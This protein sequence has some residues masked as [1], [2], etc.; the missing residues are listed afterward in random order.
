M[1]INNRVNPRLIFSILTVFCLIIVSVSCK[2]NKQTK[3]KAERHIENYSRSEPDTAVYNKSQQLITKLSTAFGS[4][5]PKEG[6]TPDYY[7]GLYLNEQGRMV[8]QIIGD[9]LA[10][11]QKIAEIVGSNDF[12]V[13]HIVNTYSNRE[14]SAIMDKLNEAWKKAD[15]SVTRNIQG[16]GVGIHHIFVD[17][18]VNTEEK[19][20][21]FRE[22]VMDSPAFIFSRYENPMPISPEGSSDTCGVHLR[23]EYPVYHTSTDK[24]KFILYN[25]S[26]KDLMCGEHYRIGF[27]DTDGHWKELPING[28]AIDIGYII[29]HNGQKEFTADLYQDV[30]PNNPGNYRFFYNARINDD[31][32]LVAD[33]KLTDDEEFARSVQKNPIVPASLLD[34]DTDPHSSIQP[35]ADDRFYAERMPEFPGGTKAMND[36]I[37][38][39]TRKAAA[40]QQGQVLIQFMVEEDGTLS[41][42]KIVRSEG[43]FLDNEARHIIGEMP[44]WQPAMNEGKPVRMKM[45]IGV[46]FY[47]PQN[48]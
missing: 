39:R 47:I 31:I 27:E 33:F 41:H 3:K 12:E 25:R 43:D 18:I 35:D 20:K 10:G 28:S 42:V 2:N 29:P 7:G 38:E 13:D 16:A 36:F 37:Y 11:R 32:R 8:V 24:V 5:E 22:K 23:A 46:D 6:I 30:H 4:I 45:T 14:L 21:E 9:S 19:R 34:A 48:K 26:G 40:R 1:I 17:L 15:K 44:K